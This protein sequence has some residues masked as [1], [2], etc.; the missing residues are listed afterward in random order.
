M[1]KVKLLPRPLPPNQLGKRI[2]GGLQLDVQLC[3]INQFSSAKRKGG[4]VGS[5]LEMLN[6]KPKMS[7]LVC[8]IT[9]SLLYN[10]S[11]FAMCV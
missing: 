5:V 6:K 7:T 11:M 8:C 4:G 9:V 2:G 10:D 3:N 1:V